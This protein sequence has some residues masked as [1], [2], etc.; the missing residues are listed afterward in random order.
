MRGNERPYPF[1]ERSQKFLDSVRAVL[2]RAAAELQ[3]RV[4]IRRHRRRCPRQASSGFRRWR[5]PR[6]LCSRLAAFDA[7]A[8]SFMAAAIASRTVLYPP[9]T[10]CDPASLFIDPTAGDE[11]GAS[12]AGLQKDHRLG[13]TKWEQASQ[14]HRAIVISTCR[15]L[16]GHMVQRLFSGAARNRWDARFPLRLSR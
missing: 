16:C 15:G 6:P 11:A 9:V 14:T 12:A 4:S 7:S 10:S 5:A 1:A 3:T 2:T 13:S 8:A